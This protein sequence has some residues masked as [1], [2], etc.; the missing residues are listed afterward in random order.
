MQHESNPPPLSYYLL[1]ALVFFQAVSGMIGGGALVLR[2]DGTLVHL[3]LHF[4]EQTPFNNYLLPGLVLF[5][6]L[7]LF[8]GLTGIGLWT[9]PD[10]AWAERLNPYAGRHWAWAFAIYL[11]FIL[12][13]WIDIQVMLIGYRNF[14]QTG[15]ALLGAFI[16]LLVL[17]PP[18]M[19]YL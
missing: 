9:R 16:L 11:G 6:L 17:W 7:G 8:P 14:L 3:P 13:L 15:Y 2:P 10:W 5:L 4:L 12:I 18:V 1:V 19:R